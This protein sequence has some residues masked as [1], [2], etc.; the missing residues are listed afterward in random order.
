[1]PADDAPSRESGLTGLR[2]CAF[3]SRKGQE[4]RLLLE[5]QGALVTIAPS[6]RE[7]PLEQHPQVFAFAEQ[8]FA[9]QIDIV[10]LLTGVGTRALAQALDVK[11]DRA[12]LLG[13]LQ[14]CTIVVRGP[15]PAS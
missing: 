9:G 7:A 1:M 3:E 5:R 12:E 8:L 4:L 10:I 2:V 13:A 14:N 15:K 6:M 11:Y